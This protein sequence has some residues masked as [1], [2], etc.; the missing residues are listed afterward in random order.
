[1]LVEVEGLAF[2][3]RVLSS[4]GG[5]G[6]KLPPGP[7]TFQLPPPPPPIRFCELFFS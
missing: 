1:M 4:G 5:G 7:Q 3:G 2:I 6:A